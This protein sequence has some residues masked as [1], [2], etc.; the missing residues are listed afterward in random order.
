MPK[1]TNKQPL[2]LKSLQ[3]PKPNLYIENTKP[4][5]F[6]ME[7]PMLQKTED[8]RQLHLPMI[9]L[10]TR[11]QNEIEVLAYGLTRAAF[12]EIPKNDEP[13]AASWARFMDDQRALLTILYCVRL[14]EDLTK[15]FFLDKQQIEDTYTPEEVGML[16]NHYLTV[17]L[18]QPHMKHFDQSNPEALQAIIDAIKKDGELSDFFLNGFTTHSVNQLVKSLVSRLVNS[19]KDSGS[20]G[21]P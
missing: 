18:N 11:E 21:T 16:C 12:K 2:D 14:P 9:V 20:P 15:R 4:G 6:H 5:R 1:P 10:N 7:V 17:R 3:E 8:G 13:G 19:Q